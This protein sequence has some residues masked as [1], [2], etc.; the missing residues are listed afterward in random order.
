MIFSVHRNYNF[1]IIKTSSSIM[2]FSVKWY[3][4][5]LKSSLIRTWSF[6]LNLM[7]NLLD[8]NMLLLPISSIPIR[9]DPVASHPIPIPVPIQLIIFDKNWKKSCLKFL[10]DLILY[11]WLQDVWSPSGRETLPLCNS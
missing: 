4:E 10:I 11:A 7:L 6:I 9:F 2:N 5:N 1:F 8:K 3:R